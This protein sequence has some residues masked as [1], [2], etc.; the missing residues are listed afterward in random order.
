[1][2]SSLV[3]L[4]SL[5]C[6]QILNIINEIILG[7]F[8]MVLSGQLEITP[9]FRPWTVLTKWVFAGPRIVRW[10]IWGINEQK[11]LLMFQMKN[12]HIL[13]NAVLAK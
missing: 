11:E 13:S 8:E 3:E 7:Q 1:M 6:Q 9:N 12:F 2:V 10:P 5:N 4:E